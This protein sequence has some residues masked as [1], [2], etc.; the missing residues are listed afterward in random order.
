VS[1]KDG[2]VVDILMDMSKG[3]IQGEGYNSGNLDMSEKL[4]AVPANKVHKRGSFIPIEARTP[5][6]GSQNNQNVSVE[7]VPVN[8]PGI[9]SISIMQPQKIGAGSS[10]KI[11]VFN[12]GSSTSLNTGSINQTINYSNS[13]RSE[14]RIYIPDLN[15]TYSSPVQSNIQRSNSEFNQVQYNQIG[16]APLAEI[17]GSSSH[18]LP[19]T[20]LTQLNQARSQLQ[21]GT[22]LTQLQEETSQSQS[23]QETGFTQL[24]PGTSQ[25]Q[26]QQLQ[27]LNTMPVNDNSQLSSEDADQYVL[28]TVMPE[29]G[30]ETVIHIYRLHGG[31]QTQNQ[32]VYADQ[33]S[34][35]QMTLES[36]TSNE[37]SE[38]SHDQSSSTIPFSVS[39]SQNIDTA[40]VDSTVSDITAEIISDISNAAALQSD[41]ADTSVDSEF[42]LIRESYLQDSNV[43]TQSEPQLTP[44]SENVLEI[45][46]YL[47]GQSTNNTTLNEPGLP[48]I[49]KV[50][51]EVDT[52]IEMK[53][54]VSEEIVTHEAQSEPN[55]TNLNLDEVEIENR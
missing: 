51:V 45:Q 24:Q 49:L 37:P 33:F 27:V 20:S 48:N 22:S 41:V 42:V 55:L 32:V 50:E 39:D 17:G 44:D 36:G 21:Q 29:G 11:P 40:S 38:E 10:V 15:K 16:N 54:E 25:S 13:E 7:N 8:I 52:K 4:T 9:Q 26:L 5:K 34:E 53:D 46:S 1:Q 3:R 14:R 6:L 12:S 18:I 23:Q 31:G 35:Q 30:G 19:G 28:V 43:T 2:E 47:Q